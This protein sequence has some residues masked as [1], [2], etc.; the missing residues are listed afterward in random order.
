MLLE[1]RAG[2]NAPVLARIMLGLGVAATVAAN[3]A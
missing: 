3:V 1:A 2:Q